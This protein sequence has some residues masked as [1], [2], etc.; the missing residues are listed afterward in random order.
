MARGRKQTP[1][2]SREKLPPI[3]AKV[4]KSQA[5]PETVCI[6]R[7]C[8][9]VRDVAQEIRFHQAESIR[10]PHPRLHPEPKRVF[11][12]L[13]MVCRLWPSTVLLNG[14]DAKLVGRP[15]VTVLERHN[16]EKSMNPVGM[17]LTA[18]SS[19]NNGPFTG[20][21]FAGGSLD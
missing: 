1:V 5:Q 6:R 19:M 16:C 2:L 11:A 7:D 20:A 4:Y 10:A 8:D 21:E 14:T 18:P 3:P 17:M 13:E 15:L 9:I 12:A